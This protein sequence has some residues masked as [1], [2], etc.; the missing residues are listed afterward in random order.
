MVNK[1]T[2]LSLFATQPEKQFSLQEFEDHFKK[3]H[4]T[5]K[6]YLDEFVKQRVLIEDRRK[7]FLFYSLNLKNSLT[8]DS[9]SICEKLRMQERLKEDILLDAFYYELS[10]YLGKST[11]IIF[12]SASNSK[13]YNDIDLLFSGTNVEMKKIRE[14]IKSFEQTYGKEIHFHESKIRNL[15]EVF[16][17]ELIRKHIIL[18]NHDSA[19]SELFQKNKL[20]QK[21]I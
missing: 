8:F 3:P 12:G 1:Y 17:Q 4:Q 20:V 2:Y 11:F 10:T 6:R 21:S 19:I 9:L 15:S 13:K 14:T 5:I 18:N 7:K 16:R